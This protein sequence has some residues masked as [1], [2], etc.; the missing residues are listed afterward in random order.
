MAI[1][2]LVVEDEIAIRDM[3]DF[4][5]ETEGF[6]VQQVGS[7]EQGMNYLAEAAVLP[8]LIL[9]DWML[10]GASG[11]EFCRKLKKDERLKSIPVIMLTAR[12]DEDDK[13]RGLEV[14]ADDYILKPF[15]PREL[16]ARVRAVLRRAHPELDEKVIEIGNLRIETAGHRVSM[17]GKPINLGPT[18]YKILLFFMEHSER[19]FSREQLLDSVWGKQVIVEERTVDVHIRRLRKALAETGAD[20]YIQ[21]VRG[22]GY[23]FSHRI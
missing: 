18:E 5:L 11:I 2:I 12:T 1:S 20:Q 17:R 9:L 14:G 8:D 4:A 6:R 10:P 16:I 15:S 13:I 23:R 7:A 21:T 3:L 22:A 19:V